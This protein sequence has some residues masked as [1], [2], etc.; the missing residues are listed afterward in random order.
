MML[1]VAMIVALVL[2]AG[3]ANAQLLFG[4]SGTSS[5]GGAGAMVATT[6]PI[7]TSLSDGCGLAQSHGTIVSTHLADTQ[8]VLDL[9]IV[10]G[11]GYTNGTYAWTSSGGG[12]SVNASGTITVS[13]GLLGGAAAGTPANFAISNGG[14]GCTSRPTISVPAGAGAGTGGSITATVY[15]LTPHNCKAITACNSQVASNWNIPGVDYPVGYDTTLALL[16][17]TS[18][19]LPSGCTFAAATVTCAGSGGTLNGYDFSLHATKLSIT[20]N[21]WTVSNNKFV[22]AS[23][24]AGTLV[25]VS[26]GVTSITIKYN[27]F[28]GHSA[29]GVACTSGGL[30]ANVNSS[31]DSGTLVFQFNYCINVDSKCLNNQGGISGSP[32]L[33]I[34]EQYNYY[35]GI[36]LCG[37]GCAHGEAEYAYSGNSSRVINWTLSFNYG[38]IHFYEGP[39]NATST[40]AQE[41]D[42][43]QLN[44]TSQYN[45][46]IARGN[47]SYTGSNN[48]TGQVASAPFYL[49]S[50]TD[51]GAG[52]LTGSVT[53]NIMD[54][55]G[56]FYPYNQG[57]IGS[58]VPTDFNAGTGNSCNNATCN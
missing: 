8:S 58:L 52:V 29:L 15:Q 39:G 25:A 27:N 37:G 45:F 32:T 4:V 49:G 41:A 56:G 47:Q 42:A 35:S 43:Y 22:C 5:G 6:C 9:N 18:A 48:N 16:D 55:S 57:G 10:G 1:R 34:T 40:F 54:Y 24:I 13:G 33:A 26:N 14:S 36:G 19:G 7:V 51:P 30:V 53:G 2:L 50:Q 31:Q 21:G 17:P 28:D 11:S 12:C 3:N 46:M 38:I 23:T 20:A 44:T